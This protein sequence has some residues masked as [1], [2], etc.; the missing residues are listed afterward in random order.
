M[1]D[2]IADY[3]VLIVYLMKCFSMDTSEMKKLIDSFIDRYESLRQGIPISIYSTIIHTD[4]RKKMTQLK[5]FT[6]C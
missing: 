1:F 2:T 3:V 6:N 4:T 5:L